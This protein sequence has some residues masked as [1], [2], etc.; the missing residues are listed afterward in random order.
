MTKIVQL[1]ARDFPELG[2]M[3]SELEAVVDKY[4]DAG[5]PYAAILGL[6]SILQDELLAEKRR[7]D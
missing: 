1:P 3:Y 6:L 7:D 5:L 4:R 2:R